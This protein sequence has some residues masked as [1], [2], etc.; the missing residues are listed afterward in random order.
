MAEE[1]VFGK[2]I[3]EADNTASE[4]PITESEEDNVLD[5][6][7]LELTLSEARSGSN[8]FGTAIDQAFVM[9][10]PEYA[11][12]ARLDRS[13]VAMQW[14]DRGGNYTAAVDYVREVK[15]RWGNGVS[16]LCVLYNGTGERL[17]Y[18][19]DNDWWGSI[20]LPYPQIIENGQ[21]ACF[22]HVKRTAAASGSMGAVV[23]RGKNKEGEDTDWLVAWDNPWNTLRFTNQAYAE[24]N[25][26]GHYD[27]I[28]WEALG[29]TISSAGRQYRAAWRG[30]VAQVQTEIDTSP[31]WEGVLSL[32]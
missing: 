10:I 7:A 13:V 11:N 9:G 28:D 21:W 27:R 24:I 20:Y 18:H 14:K 22:F 5:E 1:N 2:P 32:E 16:T 26:A 29:R 25:Q 15:R 30:C 6:A 23:Y 31:L 17:T 4:K 3:T 12:R 8:L 19:T